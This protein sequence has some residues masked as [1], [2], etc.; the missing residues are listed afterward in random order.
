MIESRLLCSLVPEAMEYNGGIF[1]ALDEDDEALAPD[2]IEACLDSGIPAKA[3]PVSKALDL[4]PGLNPAIRAAVWVPD[5]SFDAFR[6]PLAFFAAA[7]ALGARIHAWNEVVGFERSGN[8]VIA[9]RVLDRSVQPAAERRIAADYFVSATGAWA[10]IVGRLAGV[11]VDV[12]PAPGTMVAL[13]GRMTDRVL[14]HLHPAGDGDIVVPQRGLIIVG[15]TERVTEDPESL[16][17]PAE[18]IAFLRSRAAALVPAAAS[19]E[20]HAAWCAAR[21]LAGRAGNLDSGR[22]LS[23][24]FVVVDHAERDGLGGLC[25][26]VGG[27]ATVLRAMAEKAADLVCRELGVEA[28]CRSADFALPSWRDYY[29]ELPS[30][31]Q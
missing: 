9:A 8:R 29:R 13:R 1:A 22:S 18:D 31:A 5:G 19:A 14:S 27:K 30:W 25:T 20:I 16:L 23:R 28:S 2:F 17:P 10:G 26:L 6:V 7:R 3:L 24:D 21:P 4:E 11:A 12:T 15:T